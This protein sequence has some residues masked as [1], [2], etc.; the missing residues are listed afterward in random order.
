MCGISG[1][2]TK[3]YSY[4]ELFEDINLMRNEISHRG[5]DYSDAWIDTELGISFAHNRLS[6]VDLSSSG[7][8]PM[9]SKN[10]NLIIS[11]NGEIYNYKEIKEFLNKEFVD[12]SFWNGT[13]DTEVLLT[14]IE[15]LGL[16]KTLELVRG[17][18][19]FALYNKENREIILVRD[20]FGEKPLYWGF[21]KNKNNNSRNIVFGSELKAFKALKYFDNNLSNKGIM[22]YLNYG[23]ISAPLSIYENIFQLPP[24]NLIRISQNKFIENYEYQPEPENWYKFLDKESAK[25]IDKSDHE[26]TIH[27]ENLLIKSISDQ[28]NADVPICT[29]LSGGID[30][31]IVATLLQKIRNEKINTLTISFPDYD[32]SSKFFNEGPFA[33]RIAKHLGTNHNDIPITSKEALEIIPKMSEIYS[34]PFSDSSQIATYLLCKATKESSYKVALTGDGA[35]EL[36]GGYNRHIFL[37]KIYKLFGKAPQKLNKIIALL[38]EKIPLSEKGL[39]KDKRQKLSNIISN[40]KNI[41]SSYEGLLNLWFDKKNHVLKKEFYSDLKKDITLPMAS[42][43]SERIMLKDLID[44][45]PSDILVKTDRASMANS[46]E[47]RCPFLDHEIAE[48]SRL[49]PLS[50]KSNSKNFSRSGKVILKNI[51]GKYIPEELFLRPKSGFSVPIGQWLKSSL[52]D[53]ANEL[54][55]ENKIKKQGYLDYKIIKKLWESHL[56]NKYDYTPQLWCILMWQSWL[57]NN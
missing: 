46:I 54:L 42:T 14:A 29:F 8:Q 11:F 57:E 37:P 49:I 32:E 27:L 6:I 15:F 33:S 47:T 18:F 21:V 40:S 43:I 4:K 1:L 16:N 19:A 53:W 38:I 36:F 56:S 55:S 51:L 25:I 10:G 20:R 17:M 28:N 9:K 22:Q 24:G 2:I 26:I 34:E 44:Y 13:S 50:L 5:P 31:S 52:K 45:L 30:S 48:F 23:Y 12:N 3:N 41:E 39:A 35:D 7:N